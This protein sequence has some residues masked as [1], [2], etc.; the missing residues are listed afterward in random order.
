MR[1]DSTHFWH[2]VSG[3]RIRALGSSTRMVERLEFSRSL[4]VRVGIGRLF[5][6][7]KQNRKRQFFFEKKAAFFSFFLVAGNE[8]QCKQMSFVSDWNQNDASLD[9][10]AGFLFPN[11]LDF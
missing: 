2:F 6:E 9:W 10:F 8:V 4:P 3:C 5:D 1:V 11:N 7:I